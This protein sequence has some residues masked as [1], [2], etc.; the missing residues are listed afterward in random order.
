MAKAKAATAVKA[1]VIPWRDTDAATLK[2]ERKGKGWTQAGFAAAAGIGRQRYSWI[3]YPPTAADTT[4][5]PN[6]IRPKVD[7]L[8]LI[9]KALKLAAPVKDGKVKTPKAKALRP[10]N[11]VLATDE[12]LADE[13][14]ALTDAERT[15]LDAIADVVFPGLNEAVAE[16]ATTRP[17]KA[18]AP[19]RV[20]KAVKDTATKPVKRQRRRVA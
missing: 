15:N 16:Q 6:K 14:A 8:K 7:E 12:E 20:K 13:L 2:A 18:D 9:A 1:D 19:R 11:A 4:S 10:V 3:E 17:T 5:G